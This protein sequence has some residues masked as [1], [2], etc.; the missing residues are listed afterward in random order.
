LLDVPEL[1]ATTRGF[2]DAAARARGIS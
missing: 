2:I 1:F